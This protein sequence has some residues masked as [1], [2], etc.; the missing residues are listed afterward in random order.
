MLSAR[1][2]DH[3]SVY[4]RRD[5]LGMAA[6]GPSSPTTGNYNGA[7][8]YVSGKLVRLNAEWVTVA[9]EKRELTVP[10]SAILML[11]VEGKK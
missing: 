1:I 4:L 9:D 8:T 11:Q 7:D 6:D 5:A 2:G 3:C 10:K